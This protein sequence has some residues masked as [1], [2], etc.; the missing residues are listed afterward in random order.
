MNAQLGNIPALQRLRTV[1]FGIHHPPAP[2]GALGPAS[3]RME[4]PL[5]GK[6][7]PIQIERF[8]ENLMTPS[9]LY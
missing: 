1:H 4:R 8:G 2:I 9:S 3:P 5:Q 6:P 7:Q